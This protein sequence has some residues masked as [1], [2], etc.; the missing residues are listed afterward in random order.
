MN[1]LFVF[2]GVTMA[3]FASGGLMNCAGGTPQSGWYAVN[4]AV[5]PL[6]LLAAMALVRLIKNHQN[7]QL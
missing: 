4:L 2:G 5:A 7:G 1:D 3:S 6:L